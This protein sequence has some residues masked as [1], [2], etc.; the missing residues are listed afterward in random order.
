MKAI[1][2][3][4]FVLAVVIALSQFAYA[5]SDGPAPFDYGEI[6]YFGNGCPE[7]SATVIPSDDGNELSILFND[8]TAETGRRTLAFANCNWAVPIDIPP[9]ISV[10]LVGIDWRGL[11]YIPSGGSGSFSR[12]YFF[13]GDSGPKLS[14]D[15]PIYDDF[16]DFLYQDEVEVIAWTPCGESTI[17][18]SNATVM[19]R[20]PE[21]WTPAFMSIFSEDVSVKYYFNWRYCE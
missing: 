3:V 20:S 9:G 18:R 17:A 2:K 1:V 13:A 21:R 12:E 15:V 7:G 8:F 6:V 5:D 4:S 19:V 16:Y 11:A 14:D 10:G